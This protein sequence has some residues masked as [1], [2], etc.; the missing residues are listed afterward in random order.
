MANFAM[1]RSRFRIPRL[2]SAARIGSIFGLLQICRVQGFSPL[3]NATCSN[4]ARAN[5]AGPALA[6]IWRDPANVPPI[7]QAGALLTLT[8][9]SLSDPRVI[10]PDFGPNKT[11]QPSCHRNH[12]SVSLAGRF[13][14]CILL[15]PRP[16]AQYLVGARHCERQG[17]AVAT[18]TRRIMRS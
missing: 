18:Q 14:R 3:P 13:P 15:P 16:G 10:F 6:A 9:L 4:R 2:G 11:K 8:A 5:N 1:K 12:G 7:L 17:A